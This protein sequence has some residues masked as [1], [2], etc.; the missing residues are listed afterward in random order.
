MTTTHSVIV[1]G[2]GISGLAS[3][4]ALKKAGKDV[5]LLESSRSV[6]GLIKSVVEQ[7]FLFEIGPQSFSATTA[8]NKLFNDLKISA[9]VLT[10]PSRAPRYILVNGQLRAVPLSPPALLASSLLSWRTKFSLVRE[11]FGKTV[12]PS[13][14]E[15]I[16]GF[17]RRKFTSELLELLV[18][19]F[20]SGIYAGDPEK[21]SLRAA[22]PQ[23]H[24]AEEEAG[25]IVRGM[26][27]AGKGT[28]PRQKPTLANFRNGNETLPRSIS[29]FL[30]TS[31]RTAVRVTQISRNSSNEFELEATTGSGPAQFRT[32]QIV[33]ATPAYVSAPLIE[34]F[35]PAAS[36]ILTQLEYVSVAVVSLGYRRT[37]VGHSL[38]GFGFLVPRSAGLRVLGTVWNSSLFPNRAPQDHFL[39][40]SFLGGATDPSA[41]ML[42]SSLLVNQTHRELSPILGLKAEP[43]LTRVTVHEHA[44]PQYAIG[45]THRIVGLKRMLSTV[46]GLHLVGNY[47]QGP[48]IGACVEQA[49]AVAE[50]IRIG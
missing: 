8:L 41:A 15:S 4:H 26:K 18:G 22:F 40:T 45:H 46:S 25:S 38:D 6:G 50:S 28:S 33:L 23:I 7:D 14:D 21:L 37:D 3:A 10:A 44:I 1:V 35:L 49:Q 13:D 19:P 36:V 12:P 32:R 5:L 2:A 16:A 34:T 47:L 24:E 27:A 48:S 30:G 43:V 9:D 17:V 42:S 29:Q 39:L 20:V 31:L 11:A